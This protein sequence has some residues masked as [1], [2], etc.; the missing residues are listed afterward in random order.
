MSFKCALKCV[1]LRNKNAFLR[2]KNALLRNKT[3]KI[4]LFFQFLINF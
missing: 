4:V 2:N 3:Q 1:I